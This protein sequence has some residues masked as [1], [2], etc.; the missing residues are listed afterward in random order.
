MY[1]PTFGYVQIKHQYGEME[2][3]QNKTK[4]LEFVLALGVPLS[5]I[6]NIWTKMSFK[7][8]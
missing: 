1:V 7:R 4:Y 2:T 3:K 8:L 5:G 6:I